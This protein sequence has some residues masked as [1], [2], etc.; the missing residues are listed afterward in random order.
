M[1]NRGFVQFFAISLALICLFYLSFSFATSYHSNKAE[2]YALEANGEINPE[3]YNKYLDS[4]SLEKVWMG[5][6]YK[7]CLESEVS[8]GLD[9]KGGMNVILEVSVPDVLKSLSNNRSSFYKSIR[10][11]I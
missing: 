3:K 7:E 9:L 8:L 10:I 11:G 5:Y 6:T 1:Q 4:I 2:K